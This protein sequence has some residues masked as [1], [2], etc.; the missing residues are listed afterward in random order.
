MRL[1]FRTTKT[2]FVALVAAAT[3]TSGLAQAQ[4]A[5]RVSPMGS[6]A[7]SKALTSS[8]GRGLAVRAIE[9]NGVAAVVARAAGISGSNLRAFLAKTPAERVAEVNSLVERSALNDAALQ[10]IS[11][12][13]QV[14][15]IASRE[16][17]A[18]ERSELNANSARFENASVQNTASTAGTTSTA[19]AASL[20]R[21]NTFYNTI[22]SKITETDIA[23]ELATALQR[24][25][26]LLG[27]GA[28]SQC[29]NM[30]S[31]A[32]TNLGAMFVAASGEGVALVR[33]MAET[34]SRR[35]GETIE[36]GT[37]RVCEL[38]RPKSKGGKCEI[39][40]PA[41]VAAGC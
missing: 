24:R 11:S 40:N 39:L 33:S 22:R 31:Q 9:N 28:E 32:L 13:L 26:E 19:N 3:L 10:T 4:T 34:L 2:F 38:A 27:E 20:R 25:P 14:T 5:V 7:L 29:A 18:L 35:V 8:E 16:F 1:N 30:G 37:R 17:Q 12:R 15:E 21:V 41:V 36:E 6:R 23:S